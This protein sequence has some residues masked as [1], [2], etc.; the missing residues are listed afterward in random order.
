[1]NPIDMDDVNETQDAVYAAMETGN[2]GRART[3]LHELQAIDPEAAQSLRGAVIA[4]YG[5]AL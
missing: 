2:T 1:M 5:V 3:I 4:D